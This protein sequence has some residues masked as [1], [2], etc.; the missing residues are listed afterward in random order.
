MRQGDVTSELPVPWSPPFRTRLV[1]T[2]QND[3]NP[4]PTPLRR[5]LIVA[6]LALLLT[7]LSGCLT[8]DASPDPATGGDA[9][10][11][12][13]ERTPVISEDGRDLTTDLRAGDTLDAPTWQVGDWFGHHVFFGSDDN[14]GTHY[15]TV[16]VAADGGTYTLATDDPQVAKEHSIIDYPILGPVSADDLA[17]T[18]LGG[19]WKIWSFPLTENKTWEGTIPNI[20][21]D[22]ID[23]DQ[24]PLTFTATYAEA[25][26]TQ[27]ERHPGFLLEGRTPDGK[28]VVETDYVPALGWYSQLVVYDTDPDQDPL[29]ITVK[30]MGAGTGWTGTYYLDEA[31][32]LIVNIDGAG[33]DDA[34]PEGEPFAR[35]SPYGTFTVSTDATY[36]YGFVQ[37][38][39]VAG[40]R[41]TVL[42]PPEGEPQRYEAVGAP[43]D[44]SGTYID[45]AA[46]PGEW[47]LATAGAGGMS[48]SYVLI[49]EVVETT[50][51]L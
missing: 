34:P 46:I 11:A 27:G 6:T 26:E 43:E 31:T 7:G 9:E 50:G 2:M 23:G 3:R 47:H 20:H 5:T 30:G 36:L 49:A 48:F 40:A 16:V 8:D 28:L 42:Y 19:D 41:T 12:V 32:V 21:L 38:A 45:T 37:N 29:E 15:D 25:I 51:T 13:P 4:A 14:T 39:A 33:L 18:G 1:V 17:L 22:T 35:V 10:D 24:I 44:F